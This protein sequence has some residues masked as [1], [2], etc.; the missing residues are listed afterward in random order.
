MISAIIRKTI[1][2]NQIILPRADL[3]VTTI[4]INLLHIQ[5]LHLGP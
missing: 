3:K 5:L 2:S 4:V 1:S